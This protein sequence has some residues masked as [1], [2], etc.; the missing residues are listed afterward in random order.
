MRVIAV[1]PGEKRLGIAV[2]DPSGTIARPLAV[3]NHVSYEDNAARIVRI[4]QE[5]EAGMILIG[6]SLDMD[7]NPTVQG[8]RAS[9]LADVI[10]RKTDLKVELWDESFSTQDARSI[11]IR[12]G[13]SRKKRS[14]HLDD[15]AAAVTLQSFL[16]AMSDR[17]SDEYTP[18]T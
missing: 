17:S 10:R 3:L 13:A 11:R 7:G 12:M 4:A 5:Q 9:R 1:D 6:Q 16:D 15:V 14:G 8:K 2:S 18:L